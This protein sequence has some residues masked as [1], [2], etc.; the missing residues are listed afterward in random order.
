MKEPKRFQLQWDKLK[1]A[2][3]YLAERSLHDDNFG[4]TKLVNLLYY[5]D[6]AAYV[7]TGKPITGSNYVHI[8][9]GP[10]P[11]DW[12]SIVGQL[13]REEAVRINPDDNQ[14][15]YR[16]WRPA[17]AGTTCTDALTERER[18]FLDEQLRRFAEFNAVQIE[19]Y[20]QDE[21]AWRTT[22]L[23]HIIPWELTGFRMPKLT[24]DVKE[25]GQRIADLIRKNGR[26]ISRVIV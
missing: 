21:V 6:C 12:N 10:S 4:E 16:R 23:G 7:R 18:T 19:V 11:E 1:A 8:M 2:V 3:A 22:E 17:T 26:Q 25:R 5:A 9:D 20:S 24:D 13:E 14:G 15:G